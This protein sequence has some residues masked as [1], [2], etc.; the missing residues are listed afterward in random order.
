M[1]ESSPKGAHVAGQVRTGETGQ[2]WGVED[3]REHVLSADA[4]ALQTE[5]VAAVQEDGLQG[6]REVRHLEFHVQFPKPRNTK[7]AKQ[8]TSVGETQPRPG[9]C[10]P[11]PEPGGEGSSWLLV[12][13]ALACQ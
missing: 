4:V 3:S 12:Q 10:R 1:E 11:A 6:A 2:A 9:Y 5:P 13:A 7:R 8:N